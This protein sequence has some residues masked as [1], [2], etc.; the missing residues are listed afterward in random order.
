M[1][2]RRLPF[3][4]SFFLIGW[5]YA[6]PAAAFI[7]PQSSATP[8]PSQDFSD[9]QG[10]GSSTAGSPSPTPSASA[11]PCPPN[12]LCN[13][14]GINNLKDLAV[15]IG[16]VIKDLAIPIPVIIIIWA[17][18]QFLIAGG[19]TERVTTARKALAYAVIGLAIIF[20]G[21]GFI[22]LIQSIL[23]LKGK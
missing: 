13:P 1:I 8:E 11:S 4:I 9:V 7:L 18:V 15:R 6:M 16:G 3:I 23:S 21:S 5:L 2:M 22:D 10:G 12:Q 17:G 20:I 14:V 19:N